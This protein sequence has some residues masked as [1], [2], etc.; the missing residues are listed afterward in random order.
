MGAIA[1]DSSEAA[2]QERIIATH[3]GLALDIE[4]CGRK[5]PLAALRKLA[6][7]RTNAETYELIQLISLER[8]L[9]WFNA[10]IFVQNVLEAQAE[11]A[12]LRDAFRIAA[13]AA[14]KQR[15]WAGFEIPPAPRRQRAYRIQPED[16]RTVASGVCT[17]AGIGIDQCWVWKSHSPRC[18]RFPAE[19]TAL[20][21]LLVVPDPQH[22]GPWEDRRRVSV[23]EGRVV[24]LEL[25]REVWLTLIPEH[26]LIVYDFTHK[27]LQ[28][29]T[30]FPESQQQ[31]VETAGS[32]SAQTVDQAP[33]LPSEEQRP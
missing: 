5:N 9:P 33:P 6:V 22:D 30:D 26:E 19:N 13:L 3:I 1:E 25:A 21:L 15:Q 2:V 7:E 28:R 8:Q 16:I 31:P 29:V 20:S 10:Q 4:R 18:R 27:S 14:L 23:G 12:D 24:R 32:Q 11:S 17:T